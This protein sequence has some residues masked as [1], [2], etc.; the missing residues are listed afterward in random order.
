[1]GDMAG[2]E[3]REEFGGDRFSPRPSPRARF[4]IFGNGEDGRVSEA[5]EADMAAVGVIDP[6][7]MRPW[8]RV[9]PINPSL[10]ARDFIPNGGVR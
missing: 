5:A 2:E 8:L 3:R 1:M 6:A 10:G 9:R 4:Q 7:S